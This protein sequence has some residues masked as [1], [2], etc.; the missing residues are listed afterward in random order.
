DRIDAVSRLYDL[1]SAEDSA[2]GVR[3]DLYV[4]ELTEHLLEGYSSSPGRI[5]LEFGLERIEVDAKTS[6]AV[7]IIVNEL[8]TNAM[9]HAFPEDRRGKIRVRL[10]AREGKVELEV[11][12]DGI[13]A[14][15]RG[16]EPESD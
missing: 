14:E 7:G 6:M 16:I 15:G 9:K 11:A 10:A 12:D 1:L 3:L 5:L 2:R 13:G 4:K 8:A